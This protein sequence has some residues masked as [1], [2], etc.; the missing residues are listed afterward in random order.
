MRAAREQVVQYLGQSLSVKSTT[1]SSALSSL[2][3]DHEV[4]RRGV[5][6]LIDS[7]PDFEV[8]GEAGTIA[9]ALARIAAEV[10]LDL[11][12]SEVSPVAA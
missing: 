7:E 4:V 6:E 12:I 8:V 3:D 9:Q 10:M 2:L 5:A 11:T 1:T